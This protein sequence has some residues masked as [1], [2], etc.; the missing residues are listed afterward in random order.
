[1]FYSANQVKHVLVL[2]MDERSRRIIQTAVELA[3]RD[4]FTAVRLRDVAA[5]AE[6][7]LGTVYRRFPTKESILV[8]ALAL[9]SRQLQ[10]IMSKGVSIEGTPLER[11]SGFF[12][13]ATRGL[14]AKPH[15]ARA[16]LR[17]RCRC[18]DRAP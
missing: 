13:V 14:L 10:Q 11:I 18:G 5:K 6:V 4:G 12:T 8:A 3:E 17:S 15:L 7:A 1:M 2:V 16:L 9:E